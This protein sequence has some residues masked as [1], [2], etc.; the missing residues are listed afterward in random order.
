[1]EHNNLFQ[2][3]RPGESWNSEHNRA[4]TKQMPREFVCP[5][6]SS[7]GPGETSY[8]MIT[9]ENTVGG[10][11]GSPGIGQ[12]Q[13]SDSSKT[14]LVLEVHGL[15][16]PWTEPRDVTLDELDR[17]LKAGGGQIG[18]VG[19]FTVGMADGSVH[20]LSNQIDAATLRRLAAIN[21]QKPVTID[22]L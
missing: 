21:G 19:G 2:Q 12:F 6:D 11:P 1:M 8:V 9:G 17:R 18:H 3:Y 14:I 5:S 15:K 16:I 22:S 20:F 4:L 7:A 10:A 13:F